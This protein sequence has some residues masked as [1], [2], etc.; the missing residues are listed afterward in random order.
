M[1]DSS[2]GTVIIS[3]MSSTTLLVGPERK[4][5]LA[6]VVKVDNSIV[7]VLGESV[8]GGRIKVEHIGRILLI[9]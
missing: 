8:V 4:L 5:L 7:E 1:Y 6:L 3:L 9:Q 2:P